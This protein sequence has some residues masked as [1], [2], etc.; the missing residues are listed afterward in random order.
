[1]YN[2]ATV[3]DSWSLV[4]TCIPSCQVLHLHLW[5]SL[6]RIERYLDLVTWSIDLVTLSLDLVTLSLD[7]GDIVP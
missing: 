1:M 7:S 2:N 3:V 4:P 6:D 5:W